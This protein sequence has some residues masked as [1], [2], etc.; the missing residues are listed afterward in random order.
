MTITVTQSHID[1]GVRKSSCQCP[2]AQALMSAGFR[3]PT[4]HRFGIYHVGPRV[5]EPPQ[6]ARNF[7][8]AFDAGTPVQPFSFEV[9][10]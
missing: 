7:M 3:S 6:E 4:V 1:R 10:L 2:I 8:S 5:I 9:S